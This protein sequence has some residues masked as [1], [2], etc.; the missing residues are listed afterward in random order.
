MTK[1][2]VWKSSKVFITIKKNRSDC[3]FQFEHFNINININFN[4]VS[5]YVYTLQQKKISQRCGIEQLIKMANQL[6]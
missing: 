3:S 2:F 5:F 1:R 6:S 4:L